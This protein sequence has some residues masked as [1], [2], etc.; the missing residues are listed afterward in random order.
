MN[1]KIICGNLTLKK[2]GQWYLGN[3]RLKGTSL[4]NLLKN[5]NWMLVYI[6]HDSENY[7]CFPLLPISA[8]EKLT[9]K[10]DL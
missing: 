3:F 9:I 8:S 10:V 5:H 7:S 2:N 4:F 1:S 6:E